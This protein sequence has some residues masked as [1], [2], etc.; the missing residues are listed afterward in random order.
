MTSVIVRSNEDRLS[1]MFIEYRINR[2][3]TLRNELIE[4]HRSLACDLARRYANRGVPS[5]DLVQVAQLGLLN[6]VERFD[7]AR[8]CGFVSFAVATIRGELKRHFR[9]RT[10]AVHVPRSAQELHLRL[11]PIQVELLHRLQRTPT[12]CEVAA[13][14]GCSEQQARQASAAGA[15]YRSWSLDAGETDG[16]AVP[17]LERKLASVDPGFERSES[18]MLAEEIL[19]SLPPRERRILELRFYGDL[20]QTEIGERL[21]ISQMHVSRLMVRTLDRLRGRLQFA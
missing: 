2:D 7:P 16:A 3:R 20:T 14:L 1:A 19:A 5:D 4:A 13:E 21:G 8:N 9:D 10:W 15:A 18:R 6:A 11:E 12:L 17:S